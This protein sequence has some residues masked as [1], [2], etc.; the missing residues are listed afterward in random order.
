[1]VFCSRQELNWASFFWPWASIVKSSE[2]E[3]DQSAEKAAAN[4]NHISKMW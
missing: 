3:G 1:M 4:F 2:E